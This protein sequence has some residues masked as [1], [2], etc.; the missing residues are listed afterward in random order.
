[1]DIYDFYRLFQLSG[2]YTLPVLVEIKFQ[3]F[4]SLYFTNNQTDVFFDESL[5]KAVPMAYTP[6]SSRDGVQGGGT[7]E[8]D[9]E[10]GDPSLPYSN[11]L[12]FLDN[13][14]ERIELIVKAV[15]LDGQETGGREIRK[16]AQ[17]AHK[18]GSVSW[19]GERVAWNLGGDDRL[20]MV[21][22][23]WALDPVSLEE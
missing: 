16:I 7:L 12:N 5:Y 8:I 9:V 13:T 19:D 15:I 4:E 23:P 11:L 10:S 20:Q 17:L 1:M 2:G 14:D 21:I 3:D 22:N 18:Y 6:P